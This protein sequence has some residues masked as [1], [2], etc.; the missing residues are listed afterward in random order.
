MDRYRV[1]PDTVDIS[2]ANVNN[3]PIADAGPDS[4]ATEGG[5]AFLSAANSYDLDGD[6]LT[7]SWIQLSGIPVTLSNASS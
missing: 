3:A 6:T 7:Y 4:G 2:V 1:W 5:T